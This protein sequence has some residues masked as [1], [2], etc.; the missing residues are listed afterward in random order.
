MDILQIASSIIH[1]LLGTWLPCMQNVNVEQLQNARNQ[2]KW[3]QQLSNVW[4]Q[5]KEG[6]AW[7]KCRYFITRRAGQILVSRKDVCTKGNIKDQK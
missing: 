6:L 1:F 3:E 4:N 5:N 2:P 7:K